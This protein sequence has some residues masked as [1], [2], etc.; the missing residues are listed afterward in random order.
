M[1]LL[2]RI[3]HRAKAAPNS[4]A[5]ISSDRKLTFGQ[6]GT[7]SNTLATHILEQY[8]NDRAPVAVIGHREPKLSS[9][10]SEP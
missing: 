3:D 7:R 8:G 2:E 4:T 1:N 10:S 6:L 9:L 5:H